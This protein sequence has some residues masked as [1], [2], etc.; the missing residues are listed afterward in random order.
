[1]ERCVGSLFEERQGPSAFGGTIGGMKYACI[2]WGI[3]ITR[4]TQ[5]GKTINSITWHLVMP[6]PLFSAESISD[7]IYRTKFT[8]LPDIIRSW[9]TEFGNLAHKNVLDFGCG[10][11]TTALGF[12]LQN[13]LCQVMGIDIMPDVEKCKTRAFEQ[14]GL[15][16]LPGNL[17]LKQCQLCDLQVESGYFDLIYSWSVFEHVEQGI[18]PDT[19][20]MLRDRM[21]PQGQLFIQISPLFFSEDGSHLMAWV[22]EPWGHLTNQ[23]SVYMEKLRAACSTLEEF[24]SLRSMFETLNRLTADDLLNRV[25]A[26]G[27]KVKREFRTDRGNTIPESLL[28]VYHRE[29]LLNEQIVLLVGLS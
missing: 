2:R 15:P 18:L 8:V 25:K 29:V 14:L 17:L 19:L 4:R 3:L 9:I 23:H 6:S 27:F 22:P 13:P 20:A 16:E 28:K 5:A 24:A 11:G 12:A 1:M 10:E 26:A 21:K 7:D